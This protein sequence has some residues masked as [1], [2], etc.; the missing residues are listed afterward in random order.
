MLKALPLWVLST[1]VIGGCAQGD[2]SHGGFGGANGG[3]GSG[4]AG[5]GGH[6]AGASGSAGSAGGAGSASAGMTGGAGSGSAGAGGAGQAGADGGAD[7]VATGGASGGAGATG[8]NMVPSDY[9]GTPFKALSIPGTIV[10]AD[11]DRGGANVAWCHGAGCTA[12]IVTGDWYPGGSAPYRPPIP[13]TAKI[14]SGAACDD[15]VG[16]CRMN[17][18]KPDN[19]I[20]GQPAPAG[21]TYLCYSVAGQWTKYTVAVTSAGTYAVGGF[22][23]VPQGGGVNLSFG[24]TITTGNLA[25][26]ITPTTHSGSGENYH[27]W[28]QREN[29]ATVTFPSAGTYLLTVTQVGRF[30]ASSFTFVKM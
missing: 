21:A 25:L 7:A 11:Y 30:N 2:A 15:N 27:S 14:C 18:G 19:T 24:G 5:A 12:G 1:V 4:G 20:T 26:A 17:P 29:L 13:A 22:M 23:A 8:P 16:V 9:E 28:D 3:A 10:A 6:A